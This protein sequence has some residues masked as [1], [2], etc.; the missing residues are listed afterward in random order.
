MVSHRGLTGCVRSSGPERP[1]AS[2]CPR[3]A[4]GATPAAGHSGAALSDTPEPWAWRTTQTPSETVARTPPFFHSWGHPVGHLPGLGDR[5]DTTE[6][7]C[8]KDFA[9]RS[10]ELSGV[11]CLKTL[12]L[13]CY[14]AMIG[15][16]PRI[17][18]KTL[19]SLNKEVRPFFLSDTSIWSLPSFLPLAITA[20]R[21]PEVFLALRS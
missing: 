6:K 13:F 21:G 7:L 8:D 9:E 12:V 17:V 2:E 15:N 11:I 5:K 18:Q 19:T 14:W 3:G 4:P 16:T 10:G 1:R 20:F